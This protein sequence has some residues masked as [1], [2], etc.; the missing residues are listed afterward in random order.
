MRDVPTRLT[1]VNDCFLML[2]A[3][4]LIIQKL[5]QPLL[6]DPGLSQSIL[7]MSA[8]FYAVI[9]IHPV[10]L[11]L[12]IFCRFLSYLQLERKMKYSKWWKTHI[13]LMTHFKILLS[14]K[15]ASPPSESPSDYYTYLKYL[16]DNCGLH[17][18]LCWT[19]RSD[20]EFI[21]AILIWLFSDT[22]LLLP[23]IPSDRSKACASVASF[24]IALL[25]LWPFSDLIRKKKVSAGLLRWIYLPFGQFLNRQFKECQSWHIG[26]GRMLQKFRRCT[27]D[28][29]EE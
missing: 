8:T 27:R 20:P 5:L 7:I 13:K 22:S 17:Y 19:T 16:L 24:A 21:W 23:K 18:N 6:V 26:D 2:D 10:S 12:N 1:R 11:C 9:S 25:I 29:C 15:P 3:D 28:P 4:T 14:E